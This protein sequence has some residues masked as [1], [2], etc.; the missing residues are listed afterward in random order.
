MRRN[1][2]LSRGGFAI[3]AALLTI[4]V[5][6]VSIA[7]GFSIASAERRSAEDQKAQI[8]AFQLA[9]QGLE[10]FL[11]KRDSLGFVTIPPGANDSIRIT[12]TGGYADVRLDRIRAPQGSLAGLYVVRSRG[13][14]TNGVYA[15]TPQGVRTVA[16]YALWEPASMQV[17][18]GWTAMSGFQKN[19]NSGTLGG[20]DACGDS[21]AVAGVIVPLIPGYSGKAGAASGSPPIDSVTNDSVHIDWAGIVNANVITPTITMPGGTWPSFADTTYY[22][23][24]RVNGDFSLPSSGRGT[25]IVTGNFSISGSTAWNGVLLVGGSMTS[26]G[27]NGV[28][29]ATVS[30]LN[31]KLGMNVPVST[32]N[33]TKSYQYNSCEVAKAMSALGALV[34]LPNTWV[35]NWVEYN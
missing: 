29:G 6:T 32:A 21:A 3:P 2:A 25:L 12:L 17:L 34:P 5:L 19:G 1:L 13:V 15:G 16:Q 18:G 24:I 14:Q 22:P 9:E 20:A 10:T 28:Q 23:I 8:T 11:I 4:L 7:A 35:D 27:N 30:G 26:N 31:V 33:G